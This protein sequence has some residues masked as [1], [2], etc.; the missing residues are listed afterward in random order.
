MRKALQAVRRPLGAKGLDQWSLIA[1]AI[2]AQLQIEPEVWVNS[3][4]RVNT[5]PSTRK[6]F[7]IF[8]KELDAR[9][10][11]VSG[12]KFFDK[13]T[14]LFDAM[15]ACWVKM[16]VE[17]RH[18]VLSI[19]KAIYDRAI[20]DEPVLWEKADVV[21][22][23]QYVSLDDV[24]KLRACYLVAQ[25]DPSVICTISEPEPEVT[26]VS[27]AEPCGVD[28]YFAWK[29][30]ALVN[31]IK[32]AGEGD[33]TEA[34]L[35]LFNHITN[36]V[37][38]SNWN[39]DGDLLPSQALNLEHTPAQQKLLNPTYKHV[40][41]GYIL[42]DCKGKG[43]KQKLAKRR[44]DMIE[45]N[46]ASYSRCLN[47]PKRLKLIKEANDLAAT[48][49]EVTAEKED[50]KAQRKQLAM[51]KSLQAKAKKDAAAAKAEGK[52]AALLPALNAT[53]AQFISGEKSTAGL[54]DL[55]R[56]TLQD[57]LKYYYNAPLPGMQQMKKDDLAYAV[58]NYLIE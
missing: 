1:V 2:N 50:L 11:L 34:R 32:A 53:M 54:M 23:A 7:D 30:K 9:G 40:L 51:K 27:T 36:Y 55:N 42:Y 58:R 38:Q 47:D 31:A 21:R 16:P 15:P 26:Q 46:V 8:I 37:A 41:T 4:K 35:K 39:L 56:K 28:D 17:D 20:A 43:A 12:E 22:L 29:P 6:S 57:I 5:H 48:I 13:R 3:H 18:Q 25:K 24:P 19:I 14:S 10:V 33:V 49:A 52:K 44:L 45:G